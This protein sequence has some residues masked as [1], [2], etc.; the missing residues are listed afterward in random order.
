MGESKNA[1]LLGARQRG[2]RYLPFSV[3][4][5]MVKVLTSDG[6]DSAWG[7]RQN[8]LTGLHNYHRSEN[9]TLAH[10]FPRMVPDAL[11]YEPTKAKAEPN[12]DTLHLATSWS[13]FMVQT[14]IR[15]GQT[16]QGALEEPDICNQDE[17][18]NN[19]IS[20]RVSYEKMENEIK[21][22]PDVPELNHPNMLVAPSGQIW[23]VDTNT[24]VSPNYYTSYYGFDFLT[25]ADRIISRLEARKNMI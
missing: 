23:V 7:T 12:A 6:Q 5:C 2:R 15:D 18:L 8:D 24:L 3:G 20:L 16:I 9:A 1:T 4:P 14:T 22:V 21:L 25:K 19:L 13:P 17:F 10:F 11:F